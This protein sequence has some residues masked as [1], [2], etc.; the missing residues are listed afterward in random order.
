MRKASLLICDDDEL[1]HLTINS[2][3][4]DKFHLFSAFN[5][6]EALNWLSKESINLMYLDVGMRS[7]NEG[8]DY[9]EKFRQVDPHLAIVM[10]TG[11]TDYQTMRVCIQQGVKDFLSKDFT[12]DEFLGTTERVLDKHFKEKQENLFSG[13]TEDVSFYDRVSVFEKKL[14]ETELKRSSGSLSKLARNQG[15]DRS[16]LYAK[17]KQYGLF[18][19]KKKDLSLE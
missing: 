11:R 2:V 17:L 8:L 19:P 1:F 18:K 4:Q 12:V 5:C 10:T 15:M 16:H 13:A 7:P 14:L 6:D 9:L 3:V